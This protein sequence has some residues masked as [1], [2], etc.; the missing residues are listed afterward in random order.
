MGFRQADS[1]K[2]G[3]YARLWGIED[4]GNYSLGN[5]STSKKPKD[6]ETW[7]TDFQDGFVR[8]IGSAHEKAKGLEIPENKGISIQITSC[9]VTVQVNPET[10]KR[11]TKFLVFAFDVPD[12]NGSTTN[13]TKTATKTSKAKEK[14]T[15]EIEDEETEELPF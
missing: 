4:K 5:V 1:E 6:S 2:R 8:F 7:E 3:G 14:K 9:D 13:K 10:K 12:N 15:V 11:S